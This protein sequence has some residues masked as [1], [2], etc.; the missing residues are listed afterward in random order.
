[1]EQVVRVCSGIGLLLLVPLSVGVQ[2]ALSEPTGSVKG[3][4]PLVSN[5]I[6]NNQ[7]NPGLAPGGGDVLRVDYS[8]SDPD[9]DP[10]SGVIFQ[11]QRTGSA[12]SGAVGRTYTTQLADRNQSLHVVVTP[13]TNPANTDPA[14]GA[15]LASS[16][17][18]VSGAVSIGRFL[19]PSTLKRDWPS[20]DS[21][22]RTRGARLPTYPELNQLFRDA[23]STDTPNNELCSVHGWPLENM[24]GGSQTYYWS[25]SSGTTGTHTAAN[26]TR[27]NNNIN[28][29]D[30][31]MLHVTCFK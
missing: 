4:A 22:C 11:W 16:A 20:A 10:E 12:I 13:M 3:R 28:L 8:F 25:S 26:M 1:M 2:A 17:V 6:I 14:T 18:T 24:C 9:M 23:T 30:N 15:P 21:Y 7:S 5:V 31:S 19:A 27:T 29:A